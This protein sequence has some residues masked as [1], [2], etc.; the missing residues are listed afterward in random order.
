[1][2]IAG[3]SGAG[4]INITNSNGDDA[5]VGANGNAG[6]DVTLTVLATDGFLNLTAPFSN[7]LFSNS[8][9][10]TVNADRIA[11]AGTSGI[12]ANNGIVTI[13]QHSAAQ[14]IG[15]GTIGDPAAF[16]SLS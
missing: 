5:S 12:T 15:L 16:L 13:Q 7:A 4:N 2:F 9:D 14:T 3:L 8:G 10:V 1:T 11:I 6:G